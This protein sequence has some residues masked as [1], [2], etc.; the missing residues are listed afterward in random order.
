[1]SK[2]IIDQNTDQVSDKIF[3]DQI[4]DGLTRDKIISLISAFCILIA[5]F[6]FGYGW[7]A[8]HDKFYV[9]DP[10]S[11]ITDSIDYDYSVSYATGNGLKEAIVSFLSVGALLTCL[12]VH[13][14]IEKINLKLVFQIAVLLILSLLIALI[15]INPTIINKDFSNSTEN[16]HIGLAIT[17]FTITVSFN[18]TIYYYLH[19]Q[20]NNKS[21]FIILGLLNFIFYGLLFV[22]M[23][24]VGSSEYVTGNHNEQELADFGAACE[25]IQILFFVLTILLLGFYGFAN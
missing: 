17:A 8:T 11:V 25:I 18:L 3:K 4:T 2:N 21:L 7:T 20:Y 1:M 23:G 16:A 15:Y 12:L 19:K 5:I 10:L 13:N 14:R 9:G 6:G 22:T 24:V